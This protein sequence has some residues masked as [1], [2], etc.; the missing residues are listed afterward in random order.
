MDTKVRQ[1]AF[2]E[3]M[4]LRGGTPPAPDE[5]T[6]TGSD[7]VYPTVF[8]VGD[9]AAA[10]IASIGVAVS[11]LWESKTGR[12]QKVA[13]DT[14]HAA[15]TMRTN[16]FT[17]F[18]N[19]EGKYEPAALDPKMQ[20]M[21]QRT[22]PWPTRDGRW[23][24]PHLNLPHLSARVLG[25]LKC[26]DSPEGVRDGVARWNADDLEE[27][28]A[29]ARACGGKVRTNA[30]WMA[31]PQ[32]QY[33]A[34]RPLIEIEKIGD[35]APEPLPASHADGERPLSGIRVLDLTR[36]LA[37]P[38]AARTL[39]EHG[40]DVL[41][42]TAPHL[43]QTP[44]H[45]RDTSHGKRSC[46]LDLN[47][48]GDAATLRELARSADVFSQGYRPGVLAA[49]GFGADELARNRPGIVCLT[50]SCY[51]SGGPFAN[52]AGWEQIAQTV[53]GICHDNAPP[54]TGRP[55]LIHAAACDWI[56]GYLG[57]YAVLL[58]LGRRAREGGSYHVRVSLCQSGMF[59]QRQGKLMLEP[60]RAGL[61]PAEGEALQIEAD[62]PY[63]RMRFL[64]PAVQMSETPAR[65]ARSTP[66]LGGDEP[67]W[68]LGA[69]S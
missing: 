51:G 41:M 43:P 10:V 56:T 60:A 35:S 47:Q 42:V 61:S 12:R 49:R 16:D 33:L 38:V 26:E 19:A 37:G 30:E 4:S 1:S 40:A 2:D 31:H 54:D 66:K 23:Y 28:I 3:L 48:P 24:L 62:S 22:Q 46:Y 39:G 53:T 59:I 34:A 45:V 63:G 7:P 17:Y 58:A 15:A 25:V 18:R 5:V 21:R 36:I 57:A 8:R 14:R 68:M 44:E 65:W 32:G 13:V 29:A 69:A 20:R 6:I 67:R 9:T 50:I 27:A 55:T 52:R 64:R 11:D